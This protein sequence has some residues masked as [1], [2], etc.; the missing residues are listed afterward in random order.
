MTG[1]GYFSPALLFIMPYARV[2]FAGRMLISKVECIYLPFFSPHF[3]E[4]FHPSTASTINMN[5][6]V[7][8]A[9]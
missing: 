8:V 6:F 9:I 3:L 1:S 5:T 4:N 2:V 7:L